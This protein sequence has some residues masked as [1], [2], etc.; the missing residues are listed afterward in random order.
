MPISPYGPGIAAREADG[1]IPGQGSGPGPLACP[2]NGLRHADPSLPINAAG[3]FGIERTPLRK[4]VTDLSLP[5]QSR[6]GDFQH[7]QV[8]TPLSLLVFQPNFSASI[9]VQVEPFFASNRNDPMVRIDVPIGLE[10]PTFPRPIA[11]G[12][13]F[14]LQPVP[15]TRQINDRDHFADGELIGLTCGRPFG[16][17]VGQFKLPICSHPFGLFHGQTQL[18]DVS[19]IFARRFPPERRRSAPFWGIEP[20]HLAK[21]GCD[22]C[23]IGPFKGCESFRNFDLAIANLHR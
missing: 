22:H 1:R 8:R 13:C 19:V 12:F 17:G 18:I 11:I 20:V 15:W 2:L 23:R 21:T 7:R 6:R 14:G 16:R 4:K 5:V 9:E 3:A 10:H